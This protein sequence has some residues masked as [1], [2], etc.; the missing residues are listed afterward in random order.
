MSESLLRERS[1]GILG[2]TWFDPRLLEFNQAALFGGDSHSV[3]EARQF[4][5]PGLRSLRDDAIL[6]VL[7][8]NRFEQHRGVVFVS[9]AEARVTAQQKRE[10]PGMIADHQVGALQLGTILPA[11][12]SVPQRDSS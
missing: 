3:I 4:Q 8:M 6:R 10:R 1:S 7:R 5:T 11:C 9:D 12:C 2:R